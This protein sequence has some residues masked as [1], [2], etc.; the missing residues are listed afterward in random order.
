MARG[1]SPTVKV[2]DKNKSKYKLDGLPR[3][4]YINLD[5]HVGRKKYMEDTFEEW[6]VTNYER[7][8][9]HDGRGDN[10]LSEVL[11]GTY[12]KQMTS[13]EVGCTVSHLKAMKHWL[14]STD[15][16]EDMLLVMEDDCDITTAAHWGFTWNEF[17]GNAPYHF[18]CIQLA[19]INPAELHVKMHIRFV[20]DFS[21]ACYIIRRHHAEKLV[22]LHCRGDKY[23]LDQNIK[24]RA[25]ADD[26]IYNSGLTFSIPLFNYKLAF[27]SSI[28]NNHIDTFHKSSHE[29]MWNFWKQ[30]APSIEDWK[31]FFD[32][33]P[34]FG[35][36][37]PG[38]A[39][40]AQAQAEARKKTS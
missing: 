39:A 2:K 17:I 4:Y 38:L 20:N 12:P 8:S 1:I 22:K 33:D 13:G 11:K 29:G 10:D 21:T 35:T 16:S 3:I 30:S 28:H 25:V 15:E 32:Y 34:Y 14:D 6:G 24:P 9:A 40:K 18:D 27:G 36:L 26:L 7:I 19:I 37:P 31:K 23:K 5:D